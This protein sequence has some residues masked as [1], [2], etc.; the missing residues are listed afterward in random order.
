MVSL[1]ANAPMATE[2]QNELYPVLRKEL[3]GL[4]EYECVSGIL[5]WV[6]TGF[7]YEYDEKVWGHDRTFFAEETLFYPYCDCEDRSVLFTR[8]VR[9]LARL[10]CILIYYPGHLAAAVN[11][12]SNVNG[13]YILLN[14]KKFVVCDPTYIGAPVG[15][16]MPD[17]NNSSAGVILLSR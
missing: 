3:A 16:T 10:D 2:I 4:S 11:F 1:Y 7:A 6:Q 12:N 5:N 9:D 17:M 13:D 8:L 14:K 15:V